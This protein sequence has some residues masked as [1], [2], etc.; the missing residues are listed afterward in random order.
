[1]YFPHPGH[2]TAVE[3]RYKVLREVLAM[4]SFDT[5]RSIVHI[6][7]GA[8]SSHFCSQHSFGFRHSLFKYIQTKYGKRH[9]SRSRNIAQVNLKSDVLLQYSIHFLIPNLYERWSRCD[10]LNLHAQKSVSTWPR[11]HLRLYCLHR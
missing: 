4:N 10:N 11:R 6:F 7:L 8:T 2:W 1:M 5:W 9:H 3:R